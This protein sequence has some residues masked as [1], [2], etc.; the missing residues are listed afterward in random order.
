MKT[1]LLTGGAGYIGSHT[2]VELIEAG[3]NV[4]IVDNLSNSNIEVINRIKQITGTEPE[5]HQFDIRDT[6][7]LDRLFT[8]S[9]ID[10]VIH[11]A[12]YKAVAESI[13]DPLKYYDNNIAS[14]VSLLQTMMKHKVYN[15]VFSSSAAVYGWNSDVP[16]NEAMKPGICSNPYGW[17]KVMIEQIIDDVGKTYNDLSAVILRYFNPIGA[18]PS[19]LI[20]EDPTGIPNNLMPYITQVAAGKR[21]KLTIFGTDYLTDDGT[22]ERDFIHVVDVARAHIKAL[23]YSFEF[24]CTDVFN[25]G[26]GKPYSVSTVVNT[27]ENVNNVNIPVEY[28]ERRP[29]DLPEMYADVNKAETLLGWTAEYDLADM[30]RDSWNWQKNN[31]NGYKGEE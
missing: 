24:K 8:L 28:G 5:F 4:I 17:T 15:L 13:T 7:K 30:C 3:Y 1:V 31:P 2:A 6:F 20:G 9:N 23:E 16:Y 18:H 26:T 19:G 22:C 12:G 25:I 14:T 29:G 11:F 21:E 10:A 27:F